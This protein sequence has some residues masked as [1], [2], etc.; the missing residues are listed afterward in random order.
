MGL[1]LIFIVETN[2]KCKSDWVYIKETID[3]F[4]YVNPAQI[5]LSPVYLGGKGK[6]AAKEKEVALLEAQYHST[7]KENKSQTILC[8]DC[9]DYDIK[10]EDKEFLNTAKQ[11]CF[12]NG[13]DLIWFCK[14]VESVYIG[15]KVS[16]S[17]KKD[18]ATK[19]KSKGMINQVDVRKL[20][21]DTY[22]RNSSNIIKVLGKYLGKKI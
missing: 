5:K 4:F 22:T 20:S 18:E 7:S 15:K 10:L 11:Y 3:R 16:D 6:Y 8:L 12:D 21:L 2:K 1:Q 17:E 9:D 13:I 14:D 19:F